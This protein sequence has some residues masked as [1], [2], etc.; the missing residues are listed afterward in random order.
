[1]SS[2]TACNCPQNTPDPACLRAVSSRPS[3]QQQKKPD[4]CMCWAGS[5]TTAG[6][7]QTLAENNTPLEV[8]TA[9]RNK[10]YSGHKAKPMNT[11]QDT[12]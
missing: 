6:R 8:M 1:M 9:H 7:M 2:V 4:G 11:T 5:V 10:H 12:C 3:D